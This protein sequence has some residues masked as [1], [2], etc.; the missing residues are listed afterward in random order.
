MAQSTVTTIA[1]PGRFDDAGCCPAS[2]DLRAGLRASRE[3]ARRRAGADVREET[4]ERIRRSRGST[5]T[6]SCRRLPSVAR[7]T[8]PVFRS[9]PRRCSRL[10]R[11][12]ARVA[13]APSGRFQRATDKGLEDDQPAEQ[14]D[15]GGRGARLPPRWELGLPGHHVF[16]DGCKG[17][18]VL[19]IGVSARRTRA[20]R[21]GADRPGHHQ[22]AARSL[23]GSTYRTQTPIGDGVDQITEN[24]EHGPSRSSC[25]SARVAPNDGGGRIAGPT[26]FAHTQAAFAALRSAAARRDHQQLARIGGG[27]PT[28]FGPTRS[29]AAGRA[30]A[31]PWPSTSAS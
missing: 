28:G 25:R 30:V 29:L 10:A 20:G 24:D 12:H 23:K 26:D 6:R 14:R 11:Y 5:R 9:A 7:S 4:F 8:H 2:S 19:N 18:Q 22:A 31:P 1:R 21:R 15:R 27:Q 3:A 17:E 13:R 16:R